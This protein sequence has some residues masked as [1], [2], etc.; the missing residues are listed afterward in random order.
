MVCSASREAEWM[1][2]LCVCVYGRREEA[3]E[4]GGRGNHCYNL[5]LVLLH[6]I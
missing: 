6:D 2:F 5:Y 1:N 3:G 4:V